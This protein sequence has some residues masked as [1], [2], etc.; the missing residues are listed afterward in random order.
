LDSEEVG[1]T[2]QHQPNV[3]SSANIQFVVGTGG[4]PTGV[5]LDMSTWQRIV[6]AL[7][8][9]EDLLIARQAL[10]DIDAAGGDLEQ[11]GFLPWEKLRGTTPDLGDPSPPVI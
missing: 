3:I 9:A 8:D 2:T 4:E 1:M 5:L 6:Q 10:A 11:A 7:E